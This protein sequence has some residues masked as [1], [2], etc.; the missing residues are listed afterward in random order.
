ME[1]SEQILGKIKAI[2]DERK[3]TNVELAKLANIPLSTVTKI[4]NG[5]TPNPTIAN[6]LPM[7]IALGISLDEISGLK[8]S[9]TPSVATPVA[10]TLDSYAEL[11]KEKDERIKELK[12]EKEK[13][14]KEKHR[15]A[16]GL[17]GIVAFVLLLL[18]VDLLNGHF[19]YFRY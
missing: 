19:G 10:T 5:T 8:T 4:L 13:M 3:I 17:V 2:T 16:I 11:L 1:I 14:R 6:I 15:T 12:E 9:D 18:T 7:C